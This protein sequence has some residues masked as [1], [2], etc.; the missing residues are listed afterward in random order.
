MT[1]NLLT[2]LLAASVAGALSAQQPPLRDSRP[3]RTGVDL[4]SVTAT[5][6]DAKGQLVTGLERED[7]EIFED[8]E[9]M[10]VSQFTSERVP[11]S[12]ALLLDVSDS[13]YGARIAS[14][15]SAVSRFLLKLLDPADECFVMAFN[16]A[17]HV[18]TG[19][20]QSSAVVGKALDALRPSGGTAIF[21]AVIAALPMVAHRGRQRAAMVLISDGSDTASDAG[22][23]Q[24]RASLLQSDLFLY[25]IAIDPSGSRTI[26]TRVN[27][28]ALRELSDQ[29]GGRTEIVTSA[30]DLTDATARIADELNH[31]YLLGYSS[32]HPSDGHYHSIRVRVKGTGYRVRARNGYIA[33]RRE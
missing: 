24:V 21:D 26:N 33:D 28:Q 25:A 10:V 1:R 16:H 15:S 29:S 14:A 31:Q 12:L 17:P 27:V 7:F 22:V 6:L 20:T 8:G 13:M 4:T 32:P 30:D 9:P 5:V 2:A 18:L 3:Y 19:W 23:R 11:V